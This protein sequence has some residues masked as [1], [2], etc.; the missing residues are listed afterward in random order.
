MVGT[1]QTN[2]EVEAMMGG[3]GG[4][5]Q[6]IQSLSN[7]PLYILHQHI[8]SI[9]LCIYELN[10]FLTHNLSGNALTRT[11]LKSY[12]KVLPVYFVS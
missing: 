9:L 3:A 11:T 10:H 7:N 8:T 2:A 6:L 4:D 5:D 12:S 1:G